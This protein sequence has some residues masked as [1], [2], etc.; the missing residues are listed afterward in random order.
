MAGG[1][2]IW[3]SK[4]AKSDP[5]EIFNL[6][7]LYLLVT[8]AWAG[9]FYGFDTGN[10]GGILTL[11]SF[12]KA[13]GLLDIPQAEYDDRKGTIAAMVAAGG[14]AGSLLAAPTSD[15]LGRKW[16]VFLW[17]L[18]F[19]VGAAMQMVPDYDV[20]LAGRF[21]GGLGVGASS[22]LSP[23]FLAE[24]SPK[25]VR[26]SM[27]ATYNLMIVT[28]LMLAFWVNYGVSLWSRPGIEDDHAQWQTAMSIQLIPGGLMCLMIPFV[29]ETPRYLINHGKAE[30]GL[31]NLCRLR[32]LPPDHPYI[33]I[34]YRE[35]QAQ[36]QFEQENFQGHNYWVVVKDIFGNRSNLQRF[37]L[38]VL[39]FI[40]HKLTGTDSLN[41]YAPQIFELIGVQDSSSLLTTGVYGAVKVAATIFYIT[42]LV[43]RVGRRLPLLI[44]ATIQGTAM[45]YLALYLRFA[46][47]DNTDMG[48]TPA[49]GIVGIV[50]IYLY[51]FGWS[52][53]HSV[54]CYITAAE[55]FPT[56]IRSVCMGFCFFVN[57]IIDYGIT[58]ATPNMLTNVGYGAFLLYALLTYL[59]VVFIFFC[60]PELK[61][62]S[63]ESMDDLFQ[64]P[65]WTMWKHAYP[66]KKETV[67]Q[68]IQKGKQDAVDADWERDGDEE[69]AKRK[70]GAAHIETVS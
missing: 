1:T 39:L 58:R 68:G 34:E 38:A 13:F 45:L 60:L 25:S 32:Q 54:A 8:L 28:S 44:G 17:G 23:Q 51:A 41:Y 42:Y 48:G 55:I 2:S 29:P 6:R 70:Q 11:P 61:G 59:G 62:R 69:E 50:W 36:V 16:S 22:M 26:G 66:T 9:C 53:G 24:N 15:W 19:L 3:A 63:I 30:Q 65:L 4:D 46:G 37:I 12:K 64:R 21:I 43:D 18:V 35:I 67:R 49:G 57:W 27:T 33:Q 56:R 10:I 47:V 31:K 40:F 52:F 14:A 7:L 20:L 5:R